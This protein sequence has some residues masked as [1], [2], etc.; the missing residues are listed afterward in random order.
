[1]QQKKPWYKSATIWGAFIALIGV[2]L[3]YFTGVKAEDIG[4]PANPDVDQ[5]KQ[6]AAQVQAAHGNVS[7]LIGVILSAIGSLVAMYNR[8]VATAKLT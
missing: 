4:I 7:Q 5:L 1:M 8:Y 3:T 2:A 6:I